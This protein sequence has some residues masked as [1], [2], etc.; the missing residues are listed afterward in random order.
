MQGINDALD[1]NRLREIVTRYQMMNIF[2]LCVDRDGNRNRRSRLDGIEN[3]FPGWP[4]FIAENAREE[5]ET[6]ALAGLDLPR[7][8]SWSRVRAEI[9]VKER[10]FE[11]LAKQMRVAD[12]PGGRRKAMG[13]AAARRIRA[14]RRKCPEDFG[15]LAKRL[16]TLLTAA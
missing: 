1:I 16:Q 10:Y 5:L 12:G 14:I 9:S 3:A 15:N 8:W 6:W 11:P 13:V 7:E 4:V 2:I